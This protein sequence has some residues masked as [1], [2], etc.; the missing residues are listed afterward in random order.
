M[1]RLFSTIILVTIVLMVGCEM[2]DFLKEE[3]PVVPPAPNVYT[4][5]YSEFPDMSPSPGSEYRRNPPNPPE[6]VGVQWVSRGEIQYLFFHSNKKVIPAEQLFLRREGDDFGILD[7]KIKP[8]LHPLFWAIEKVTPTEIVF[9]SPYRWNPIHRFPDAQTQLDTWGWFD[10]PENPYPTTIISMKRWANDPEQ[11]YA[12]SWSNVGVRYGR[13]YW[14]LSA[15]IINPEDLHINEFGETHESKAQVARMPGNQLLVVRTCKGTSGG[16]EA[17]INATRG[18]ELAERILMCKEDEEDLEWGQ[19]F[20]DCAE[21]FR[22]W[23]ETEYSDMFP[24]PK[25]I[26]ITNPLMERLHQGIPQ[27]ES[28]MRRVPQERDS[29]NKTT[30]PLGFQIEVPKGSNRWYWVDPYVEDTFTEIHDEFRAKTIGRSFAGGTHRLRL[31]LQEFDDVADKV[32]AT[33]FVFSYYDEGYYMAPGHIRSL[34]QSDPIKPYNTHG[35]LG[36]IYRRVYKAQTKS[37]SSIESW[38]DIGRNFGV[39]E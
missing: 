32:E 33:P 16:F 39:R 34:Y 15:H 5:D 31:R 7:R 25:N 18:Q 8:L 27:V 26:I 11:W 9:T 12:S 1:N 19:P 14:K 2:P 6:P 13:V 28:R 3:E 23:N 17:G 10:Y 38:M 29:V 21:S 35:D 22:K 36:L 20:E 4:G 37:G 24:L 30:V